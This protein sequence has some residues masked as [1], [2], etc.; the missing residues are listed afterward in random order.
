MLIHI[1]I[2]IDDIS[3]PEKFSVKML[4]GLPRAIICTNSVVFKYS[5]NDFGP[6]RSE[7]S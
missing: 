3:S 6:L 4:K 2:H 5:Y 1:Y 7:N